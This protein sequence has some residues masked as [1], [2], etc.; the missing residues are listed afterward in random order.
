MFLVAQTGQVNSFSPQVVAKAV[1]EKAP[2]TGSERPKAR[3]S[4]RFM[5]SLQGWSF[6]NFSGG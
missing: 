1:F 3:N 2:T 4:L 5:I 6:V